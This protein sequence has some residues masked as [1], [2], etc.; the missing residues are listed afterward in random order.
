MRPVNT[1]AAGACLLLLGVGVNRGRVDTDWPGLAERHPDG[2]GDRAVI[3]DWRVVPGGLVYQGNPALDCVF[4]DY[5]MPK[6]W[7]VIR[8]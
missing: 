4:P 1:V 7:G 6:F 8:G 2:A 3:T 5:T